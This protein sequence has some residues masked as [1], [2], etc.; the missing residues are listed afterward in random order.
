MY[1]AKRLLHT[2]ILLGMLFILG[3]QNVSLVIAQSSTTP[4]PP[5]G[6][7]WRSLWDLVVDFP[8]GVLRAIWTVRVVEVD[9]ATDIMTRIVAQQSI[10]ISQD[11]ELVGE[12]SAIGNQM[13][14][15][16]KG[17]IPCSTPS[18]RDELAKL[19]LGLPL[20][21]P[22]CDCAD[23]YV[24]VDGRW[25]MNADTAAN[26]LFY[27]PDFKFTTPITGG[28]AQSILWFNGRPYASPPWSI[29]AVSN[30]VWSGVDPF[31]FAH[32][33][34]LFRAG[35][36]VGGRYSGWASFLNTSSFTS[37]VLLRQ[38]LLH[39]HDTGALYQDF[40]KPPYTLD[41]GPSHIYI[42]YDPDTGDYFQGEITLI[43]VDPCPGPKF[44]TRIPG[45]D[46]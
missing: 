15:N 31:F 20:L 5:A 8:G 14:F 25:E 12:L 40:S 42:G 19:N 39:W 41:T 44:K 38:G 26:P 9:V 10:D 22:R 17:Y 35:A 46:K 2:A 34:E 24:T 16:G 1:H 33:T 11:C 4:A 3:I 32:V 37:T 13:Q 29:N 7:Y 30:Q 18:F 21:P 36:P 6:M 43:A 27:H 23:A 28:Q 45:K